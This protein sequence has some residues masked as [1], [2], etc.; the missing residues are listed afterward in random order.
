[1]STAI[2]AVGPGW[3][4]SVMG[5]GILAITLTAAPVQFP[6]LPQLGAALFAIDV[7]MFLGFTLLWVIGIA[8]R[9][10][11]VIESLHDP[12]RAQLSR[13]EWAYWYGGQPAAIDL[14][15][16]DGRIVVRRG[17]R[18][19]GGSYAQRAG[20]IAVWNTTMDEH[21]YLARRWRA[22]IA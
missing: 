14:P 1:M 12:V 7:A 17:R 5:T 8:R 16:V 21:N 6:I 15:G 20:H 4:T 11:T 13:P 3:F 18:R 2:R 19:S 22:F 10:R 9:P